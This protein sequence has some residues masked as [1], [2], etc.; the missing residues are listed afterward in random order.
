M[1]VYDNMN[2]DP[3][4]DENSFTKDDAAKVFKK[5]AEILEKRSATSDVADSLVRVGYKILKI[6]LTA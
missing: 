4:V 1:G 5:A 3:N 2:L 6:V